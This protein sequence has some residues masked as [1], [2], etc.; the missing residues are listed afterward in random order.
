MGNEA[1]DGDLV[2]RVRAGDSD[3]YGELIR[4]HQ[5]G[6]FHH[7]AGMTRDADAAQD[8]VQDAFIVAYRRLGECRDP[9]R[10]GLWVFRILRNRALDHVKNIRR[11]S[12]PIE[13]AN[14]AAPKD[15]PGASAHRAELRE[16]LGAALNELTAEMRDAFLMKHMEGRSYEEMAELADASVSAMKMRVHRARDA[17][18]EALLEMGVDDDV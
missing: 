6:L 1:S 16:K 10:F 9:E 13:T 11:R 12:V 17:L 3:S 5:G 2:A 14:L 8:L 7:A 4:R 18:R 15:N